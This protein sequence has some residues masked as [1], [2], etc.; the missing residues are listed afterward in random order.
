MG[1]RQSPPPGRSLRG[2]QCAR[3]AF[4]GRAG[5][6]ALPGTEGGF[7]LARGGGRMRALCTELN[8]IISL[9]PYNKALKKN[10]GLYNLG[11]FSSGE[12]EVHSGNRLTGALTAREP[13][14][15]QPWSV[16]SRPPPPRSGRRQVRPQQGWPQKALTVQLCSVTSNTII[17]SNLLSPGVPG[18]GDQVETAKDKLSSLAPGR[19]EM[20]TRK[21]MN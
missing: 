20:H 7:R 16:S 12:T 10:T 11:Q 18:T 8:C 13:G 15:P 9:N 3:C 21:Q 4:T 6:G 1:Y 5:L 2:P 19:R 17:M 14:Q